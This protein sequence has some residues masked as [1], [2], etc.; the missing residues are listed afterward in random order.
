MKISKLLLATLLMLVQAGK[1]DKQ[2]SLKLQKSFLLESLMDCAGTHVGEPSTINLSSLDW[3]RQYI[4]KSC[5]EIKEKYIITQDGLYYLITEDGE[6]YQTYCDMTTDGGGWT[7]VASVHENNIYGKCTNGD[8]WTSTQGNNQN[9]PAGD[10]NWVNLA[11]FGTASGATSDDYKN[12]GYYDIEAAD[13][14]VWHVPN[15]TPFKKWKNDAILQYHTESNFFP[16]YGGNLY[17]LFNKMPLVW[18]TGTC[19]TDNGPAIPIIYDFGDAEKTANLYSPNGR[20]EFVP[21]FIH[22]RVFNHEKA[23]MALCSGVKAT[24]CNP[25][26][27]CVG[28]SGFF[29]EGNPRQC[30]DFHAFEWDGYGTGAG[31]SVTKQML[32]SSIMLFYR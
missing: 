7:L 22:F 10:G 12:P 13:I 5:K 6:V 19:Q 29:P 8:R 32:E 23:A 31:W 4:G 11:T 20:K 26:V 28:G 27:H 18:N 16:K 30:G 2:C 25:E 1:N 24:G 15:D 21:G 17:G 3:K 9:Y 14:S